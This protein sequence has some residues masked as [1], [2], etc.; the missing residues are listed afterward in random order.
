MEYPIFNIGRV[1]DNILWWFTQTIKDNY[2]WY[3]K[4]CKPLTKN[5]FIKK[6]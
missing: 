3:E 4:K 2:F 6:V 1:Y 5:S